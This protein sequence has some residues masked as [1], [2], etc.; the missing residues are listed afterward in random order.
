[1]RF[2]EQWD[3]LRDGWAE[4][5]IRVTLEEPD[6]ADRAAQLL[7]PLQPYRAARDSL[8]F[9]V[10]GHSDGVRRLLERLD[11]E[12]IHGSLSVIASDPVE[13]RAA[14]PP[15]PN[16]RESWL[17]ALAT[18]PADWSDVL[19]EVELDSSDWLDR[20]AVNMVPMNP[21]RD[22]ARLAF[23]FRSARSYGYGAAPEM[24][25]RCLARCDEDGIR[26]SVHVLRALSDTQPV[27]TQGPVW[28]FDGRTV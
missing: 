8:T 7:A 24:V 6:R 25:A 10:I 5:R 26:G 19:A 27:Y 21:R 13:D 16:L 22:G 4:A 15:R 28:Q 9:R 12:R 18:L 1:V 17:S 2:G 11:D 14:A 23:R 3:A 20:A